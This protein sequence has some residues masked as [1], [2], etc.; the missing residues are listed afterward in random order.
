MSVADDLRAI[1]D[2]ANRDLDAVHDFFEHSKVV[3]Q[4][5]QTLVDEGHTIT[6]QNRETGTAID[7][8]GLLSL[9]PHYTRV[10]L[11]T[12]TFRQFV[13]SFE[14]FLFNFLRRLLLHNPWQFA[15]SQLD[16][17]AVLRAA[18][19][20]EVVST[21]IVKQLNDLKYENLREWF[22]AV[23]RAVKLDCP[24]DDEIDALAAVKAERDILEHNSG[25][26]NEIY[27]RKAGKKARYAAGDQIEI[28]DTYHLNSWR[29]MKKVLSDLTAAATVR[30]AKP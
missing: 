21:V 3:W 5:L 11:A 9:A 15:K 22:A 27:L 20:E 14:A 30:I 26:V 17:E 1:L 18:N 23:N 24:S 2:R 29:L 16:F 10:Y 12:F 7:Q 25:V 4:S 13:S 8:D 6:S 28:D 19:R